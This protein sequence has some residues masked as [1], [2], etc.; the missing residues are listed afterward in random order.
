MVRFGR[1]IQDSGKATRRTPLAA[2]SATTPCV[3]TCGGA[4]FDLDLVLFNSQSQSHAE[5][6]EVRYTNNLSS[7]NVESALYV[8]LIAIAARL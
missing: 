3:G 1:A 5:V 2:A 8:N 6:L 4:I 7:L